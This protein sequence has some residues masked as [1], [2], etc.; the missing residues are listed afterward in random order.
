MLVQKG[1][2]K[3]GVFNSSDKNYWMEVSFLMC[4]LLDE[5]FPIN[6]NSVRSLLFLYL[7]CLLVLSGYK[8]VS[9]RC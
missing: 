5:S 2:L 4:E 1:V 7:L 6:V 3:G 8:K 9:F